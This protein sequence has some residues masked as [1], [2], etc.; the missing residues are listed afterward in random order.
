MQRRTR[1]DVVGGAIREIVFGLED[2]LVST[3]GTVTGVAVGSGDRFVVILSGVVLV[4][5]EAISMAAG[6]YLSSK[7]A[8]E[9]SEERERQDNAR[10]LQERIN[11]DESL[12]EFF[13]RKGFTKAEMRAALEALGRER[14]LWLREVSRLEYRFVSGGVSPLLAAIVMGASYVLGGVLVF[15]PYFFLPLMEASFTSIAV[16]ALALFLLGVWKGKVAGVSRT[17]SGAEMVAVSVIAGG[18]GV[19]MGWWVGEVFGIDV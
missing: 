7:S 1:R 11:D 6:S 18:L 12:H 5:V 2:S 13:Q 4:V 14:R 15:L 10:I 8:R 17:K 19:L 9:V 3:V 16:A